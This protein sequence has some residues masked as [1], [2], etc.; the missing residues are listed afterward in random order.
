[1]KYLVGPSEIKSLK[2]L[3]TVRCYQHFSD[4]E[5]MITLHIQQ[6]LNSYFV[7]QY[8]GYILNQ[9]LARISATTN[10]TIAYRFII[11]II[12]NHI[13]IDS[14]FDLLATFNWYQYTN[15]PYT[16]NSYLSVCCKR[17]TRIYERQLT[18]TI[19]ET[20][21]HT[22]L[23]LLQGNELTKMFNEMIKQQI[24]IQFSVPN[25]QFIFMMTEQEM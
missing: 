11:I 20:K 7:M 12:R 9:S 5:I 14:V 22:M 25:F 19:D 8:I 23:H 10:L 4:I 6:I 24:T 16:A 13:H 2:S 1:M 15:N 17:L 21:M 18:T 3:L